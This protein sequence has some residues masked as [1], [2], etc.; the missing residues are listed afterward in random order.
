MFYYID[1]S[2]TPSFPIGLG[3]TESESLDLMN[4]SLER[5]LVAA[6]INVQAYPF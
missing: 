5:L 3:K 4:E 2:F 6:V 1:Q